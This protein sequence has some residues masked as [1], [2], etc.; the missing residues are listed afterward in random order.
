MYR[1][2]ARLTRAVVP[3]MI[4]R[5]GGGII[6][7]ASL[8]V[9]SGT[10]PPDPLPH[11][12][13]YAAAKS[14]MLTFTQAL[15]GEL[16]GHRRAGGNGAPRSAHRRSACRVQGRGLADARSRT[17]LSRIGGPR[18]SPGAAAAPARDGSALRPTLYI[19]HDRFG[20]R[21]A[22]TLRSRSIT[23]SPRVSAYS[24]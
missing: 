24:I 8:L 14:F 21:C 5:G 4:R 6:N 10:L 11:R 2:M 22:A 15:A 23:G 1:A 9:L 3:G 13:T 12:A 17:T 18:L 16:K 19:C 20:S 7:V